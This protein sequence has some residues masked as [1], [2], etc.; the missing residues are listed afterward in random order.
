[1]VIGGIACLLYAMF[2]LYIAI[3]KPPELLSIVR[4]KFGKKTTDKTAV[5]VCYAAGI[6]ALA[7]AVVLFVL[8]S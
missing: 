7:G 1:M 5:I 8:A 4:K 2:S 6:L 3:A